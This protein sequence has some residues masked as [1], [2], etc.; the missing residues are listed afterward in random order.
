MFSSL[1]SNIK[2]EKG[3]VLIDQAVFSGNSFVA[4]A[5]L[6]RFLGIENF[7]TF[8]YVVL[9]IYLLMSM[10]NA[11]I[12]QPM[13]V[14]HSKFAID[15]SY[16]GFTLLA[17][18]IVS[19]FLIL[20]ATVI[21]ISNLPNLDALPEMNI[22]LIG[23]LYSVWLLHDFFRKSFLASQE[24]K[25]TIVVDCIMASIQ[26]SGIIGLGVSHLL[27][28]NAA[29]II[30]TASYTVSSFIGMIL[31]GVSITDFK[32]QREYLDYHKKEG[33]LLF[34]SSLLQWWSSNLFVVA[35]GLFLG[36]A[37]L[38]AFRLV[39]SMFGILN[40]LLQTYENYVLPKA[41]KLFAESQLQ[42]KQ[43][44]RVITQKGA[45][46]FALVLVPLFIFSKQAIFLFGG[47]QYTAYHSV[48]RG[49]VILYAIIYA[50]YSVRMPIR[51]LTLNNSFFVGYCI[52]F[53]FS[54]LT[55][56]Y[57]LQHFNITGAI[58]GLIINQLLMISYWHLKLTKHNFT[59]WT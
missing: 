10:S 19:G 2:S 40:L 21:S 6:A 51:I 50:G 31:S 29:V 41:A 25:N 3:L 34:V 49:M 16:R 17:Q 20:V 23:I 9:G 45:V 35:S 14:A 33:T 22:L 5:L 11:L 42:S 32:L 53:G 18:L 36:A 12:I 43:Y 46:L 27:T 54:L 47:D 24:I 58:A 39:Q 1:V 59:L 52:S 28:L 4:T 56:N 44:L 37:A 7:G 48:V 55:F 15:N 57:L 30:F 8:S 26:L 13:Q 38:G